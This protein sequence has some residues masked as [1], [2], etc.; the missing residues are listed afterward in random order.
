MILILSVEV[1][2]ITL[3]AKLRV[4]CPEELGYKT[5]IFEDLEYSDSDFKYITC[6]LF[7]NWNQSP[8]KVGDVG[9]LQI[10][11]ISAGLDKWFDGKD[12]IPYKYTNI[13]FLKFVLEK[14]EEDNKLILD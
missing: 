12:F 11:F 1:N 10:K 6:V 13:Q 2:V 7:P 9:Y 8:I 14:E 5:L 3:H 4:A